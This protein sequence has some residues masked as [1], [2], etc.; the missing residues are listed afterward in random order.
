MDQFR[1][2]RILLVEDNLDDI[3]ITRLA[4]KR[5]RVANH[6]AIVRD[7]QEALDYLARK[8]DYRDES[9]PRPD[10]VLLDLNLPRLNGIEVL[11]HIRTSPEPEVRAVP[12]IML[13]ASNSPDDIDRAYRAGANAFV[14]K[15]VDF[16]GFTRALEEL[17][18]FWIVVARLPRAA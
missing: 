6:L 11:E 15:P 2:V 16:D 12:V 13:T 5:C 18:E 8:G 10:L 3:E 7:G 9:A 17:A 4:L 1:A 14:T